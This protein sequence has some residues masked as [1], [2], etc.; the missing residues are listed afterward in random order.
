M[1]ETSLKR[2]YG[3]NAPKELAKLEQWDLDGFVGHWGAEHKLIGVRIDKI[4]DTVLKELDIYRMEEGNNEPYVNQEGGM[5]YVPLDLEEEGG[6]LAIK[7]LKQIDKWKTYLYTG[8]YDLHE[9]YSAGPSGGQI[10]EASPEKVKLLN[11]LNEGIRSKDE[12]RGGEATLKEHTK[13]IKTVE[14]EGEYAMFQHGDQAT[15]RMNQHLEAQALQKEVA[16]LVPAVATESNEPLAWCRMGK[17]F[18]TLNKKE[19]EIFREKNNIKKPHVWSDK[20]DQRMAIRE[21]KNK[22]KTEEYI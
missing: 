8:D 4:P 19:H 3:T 17:W 1:K 15:Y 16:K 22:K 12:N 7:A 14:V 9:A 2:G 20:E 18:V 5:A 13:G 21:G 6:G 10:P 11:R